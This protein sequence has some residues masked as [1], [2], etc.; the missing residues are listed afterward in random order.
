MDRPPARP[1]SCFIASPWQAAALV[2]DGAFSARPELADLFGLRVLRNVARDTRREHPL[3]RE[4]EQFRA[5]CEA[6]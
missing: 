6:R 2:I 3:R 4:R 5:E 1:Q